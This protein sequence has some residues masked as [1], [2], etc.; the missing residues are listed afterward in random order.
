MSSSK[1]AIVTPVGEY[2]KFFVTPPAPASYTAINPQVANPINNNVDGVII[3]GENSLSPYSFGKFIFW[4]RATAAATYACK[5]IGWQR[6]DGTAEWVPTTI[7]DL[8]CTV[9]ATTRPS[10][11]N[12]RWVSGI[13]VNSSEANY[14][15]VPSDSNIPVQVLKLDL[16]GFAAVQL[17]PG[18][19][20]SGT[21]TNMNGAM[22]GF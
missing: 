22:C 16:M 11:S 10:N 7:A 2:R 20:A 4:A 12:E 9:S 8:T 5:I 18:A 3:T 1:V 19:Q 17:V 21:V 6:I 15:V 13:T 14:E